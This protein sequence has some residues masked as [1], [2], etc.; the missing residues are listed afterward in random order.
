MRTSS[1]APIA[2]GRNLLL[3]ALSALMALF[4]LACGDEGFTDRQEPAFSASPTTIA[5]PLV[6]LGDTSQRATTISNSGSGTLRVWNIE[7][8]ATG[9]GSIDAFETGDGWPTGEVR[10]SD[11]DV[12]DLTVHY[13]P[14][15]QINYGGAIQMN[16]NVSGL[17]T[18]LIPLS[19]QGLA[20]ELFTPSN[21][22][23]ART[24]AGT[25]EWQITQ[26][27]NIGAAPLH[28][29]HIFVNQGANF[30][31]SFPGPLTAGGNLPDPST[32][33]DSFPEVLNPTDDPIMMRVW[34][35]PINDDPDTGEITI[36]SND[37][38]NPEF[39]I[40]LVGNSGSACLEVSHREGLDF[41][42][43]TIDQTTYRT[44]TMRN[45]APGTDLDISDLIITDS[46]GGV[47][48][49]R[50]DSYPGE[51][52]GTTYV[53]PPGEQTNLVIGYAPTDEV[54]NSGELL[55]VSNDGGTPN[56]RIPLTGQGTHSVCPVAVANGNIQGSVQS[57]PS[58]IAEPLDTIELSANGSYDP[59]GTNIT[60]EWSVIDRPSGSNSQLTPSATVASP[61]IWADVAG[62]YSVELTV[63]D[64]VGMA[65]C[66]PA[67]VEIT[68]I[69]GQ[70]IHVQLVWNAPTVPNPQTGLGTDLDLHYMHSNGTWG[71]NA[72]SVNWMVREKQWGGPAVLD[73]DSLYG[74]TPENINHTDPEHTAYYIGVHYYNDYGN[75]ASDATV[76]VY[77]GG[78]LVFEHRNKRIQN[79]NDLWH[80]GT[81][82]W[83]ESPQFFEIDSLVPS[84]TIPSAAGG[85]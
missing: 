63:Y 3:L 25:S 64:E 41:H 68:A 18:A 75:G 15:A 66:E 76:R 53:L 36:V 28:I 55:I 59:D 31:F 82:N 56:L 73:I 12:L 6:N 81:V 22:N 69:P 27:D 24:P 84:H 30:D 80:A 46:D 83:S 50:P 2:S 54:S 51:L 60:Y 17:E 61:S 44:I 19:T 34:F 74:E 49:I 43:A 42:L 39:R 57:S 32:D 33:S 21:I 48:S 78:V 38:H 1:S 10:L 85:W 16:T 20:P 13:S 35:H 29:E 58:V 40:N 72:W 7:I 77:F 11:G 9:S 79:V 37:P 23:F 14:T 67:R 45:C 26:I 70:D 8:V 52:P 62:F 4:L 71:N 47:F 65:S 5:F